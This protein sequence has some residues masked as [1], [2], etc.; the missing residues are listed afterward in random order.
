[1]L[2]SR[3]ADQ[4]SPPR[5]SGGDRPMCPAILFA[6]VRRHRPQIRAEV[7]VQPRMPRR[8]QVMVDVPGRTISPSGPAPTW[9]FTCRRRSGSAGRSATLMRRACSTRAG[10]PHQFRPPAQMMPPA[11]SPDRRDPGGSS[12]RPPP[13]ARPASTSGVGGAIR[14]GRIA[15]DRRGD[16][17]ILR[18][19]LGPP[20]DRLAD[21]ERQRTL[22]H[23]VR[24]LMRVRHAP[25]G[26]RPL[27]R[28]A[29]PL[30]RIHGHRVAVAA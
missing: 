19:P 15:V 20:R 23:V 9:H 26:R 22:E 18:R 10:D 13:T 17:R 27:P 30:V 2:A 1:M 24:S 25:D 5:K 16:A 14:Q 12:S 7:E 4:A 28:L 3:P 29:W 21:R 6:P 8:D 11:S